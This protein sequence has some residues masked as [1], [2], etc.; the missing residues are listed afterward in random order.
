MTQTQLAE[1]LGMK[2]YTTITKWEKDE[3]FPKGKDIKR[4]SEIFNV[5]SD[6]KFSERE[7]PLL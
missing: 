2:T 5:S 6:Y 1:M 3:N 4:L 7:S